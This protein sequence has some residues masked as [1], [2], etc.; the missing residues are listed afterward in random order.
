[1]PPLKHLLLSLLLPSLI[2]ATG[3]S[4]CRVDAIPNPSIRGARI[5][6]LNVTEV[7]SYAPWPFAFG[8]LLAEERPIDVCNVTITYTHPGWNDEVHVYVWL[9]LEERDWN[10]RFL[11][12]GG[13]GWTAGGEGG[14]AP[15][16]G[17][18]YAA[19][20]T[21]TRPKDTTQRNV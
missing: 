12:T 13:G 8:S 19:A 7:H 3:S 21:G 17:L 15:A 2:S 11:G 1:M 6:D 18:G 9:P 10:G 5:K 14:L 16:V 4:S 20:M